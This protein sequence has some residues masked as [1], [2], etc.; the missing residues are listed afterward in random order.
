MERIKAKLRRFAIAK[1]KLFE[2]MYNNIP[3]NTDGEKAIYA[4]E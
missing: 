2:A 3:V 1:K 4:Y